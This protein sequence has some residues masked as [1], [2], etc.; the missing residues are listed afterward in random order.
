MI[1]GND[2][3]TPIPSNTT[4]M[5][6]YSAAVQIIVRFSDGY[7]AQGSGTMVGNNDVLTAAHVLY[8]TQHGGYATAIEVTP[9]RA[10]ELKPFGVVYGM[11]MIVSDEWVTTEGYAGD[12][13]LITLARPIGY[14]SGWIDV[15]SV[16]GY[17]MLH[18]E[19][20]S[21]GY[22]GDLDDGEALYAVSGSVDSSAGNIVEFTD[23]LDAYGG[24]SGSGIFA[25][26]ADG[27][28]VLGVISHESRAP[29]YNAAVTFNGAIASEIQGWIGANDADVSARLDADIGLRPIIEE[30]DLMVIAFLGRNGTKTELDILSNAYAQ[31]ND[32][33]AIAQIIYGSDAYAS[34]APATMNNS[35]F[36][37]HVF[38]SVLNV[39]YT[40]EDF[41]YW[42]GVLDKGMQ[43]SDALLL[44]STLNVFRESHKLDVYETWHRSYR[45]FSVEAVAS[46]EN[47][48]L[49]AREEDSLLRG[50]GGN[51]TLIG[52]NG[53]D[54]LY[55]MGG[56]DTIT[57]GGGADF[58]TWDT[59]M[60]ID[61]ILDFNL[62]EDTLRLRSD[63]DWGWGTDATGNLTLVPNQSSGEVV[64][65]G[66]HVA[67]ASAV[68][69]LQG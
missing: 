11:D 15:G 6:S 56:N 49:I 61:R 44:C 59:G 45:D 34:T 64:L 7:V 24:Q 51:D 19:V 35:A 14:Q 57:G 20:Q 27:I 32:A 48:S 25:N 67:D 42:L 60:G 65:V 69:I 17:E 68:H 53:A 9:L 50:G 16:N 1:F 40:Q 41:S 12:Y 21:Y 26:T 46:D 22:P 58:F 52:N 23:D 66:V 43:Q 33:K 28:K 3:R 55:G 36:L 38:T 18:Q 2:N 37:T 62:A 63:F 13:G 10:G 8:S 29:D 31:G 54:Y 39:P 30:I 47:T 5:Y 4:Q